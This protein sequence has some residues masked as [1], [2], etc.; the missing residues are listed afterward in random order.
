MK[1][2]YNWLKEIIKINAT[3]N[4][5]SEMLTNCG[6]EVEHLEEYQNIKGGLEG[7]LVGLVIE[8]A[9]HP[10]AY[11]LSICKVNTGNETPLQIVCGASNVAEGQKVLVA[12]VGSTLYPTKG[13]AFKISKSKIRGEISEGMICAED[14][15]G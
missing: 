3:P 2:S 8:K 15:I 13:D 12:T 11:K 4:E 9:K 6:L 7:I 14:E 1:I 10:N 5:I